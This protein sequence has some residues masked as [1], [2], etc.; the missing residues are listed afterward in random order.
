MERLL[1]VWKKLQEFLSVDGGLYVDAMCVVIIV[2]LLAVLFKF[3]P[4]T[5]AEA[6]LW[7]ATIGTYGYTSNRPKGS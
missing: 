4:M 1:L 7:A 5:A 6:G 3:P 2:R